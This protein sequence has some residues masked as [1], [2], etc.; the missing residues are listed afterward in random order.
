MGLLMLVSIVFFL[1]S[2]PIH[3]KMPQWWKDYLPGR[4][5]TLGLDLQGGI[6]MV[7]EV[8]EEKAVE[9]IVERA[10]QSILDTMVSAK[11]PVT[12]VTR[13]GQNELT[14]E[15]SDPSKQEEIRKR[16][17][18]DFPNY[19]LQD[20]APAAARMTLKL[21]DG[22][23]LR[24]HDSV[25]NQALETIRNRIDQ[26]GVTEPLIQR[27]GKNQIVIQLPGVKDSRRAKDLIGKTA[28]LEFKLLDEDSP[29]GRSLPASITTQN[30]EAFMAEYGSKV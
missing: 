15:V 26:F 25:T 17:S 2:T 18:A 28:L 9:N 21:R 23:V 24:I 27:Q 5:I 11:L 6:H 22:E 30:E 12:K 29:V 13:T 14:L 8:D 10:S 16:L 3:G 4:G 20:A 1:P 7:L 19:I